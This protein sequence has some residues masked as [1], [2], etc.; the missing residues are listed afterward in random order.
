MPLLLFRSF[1]PWVGVLLNLFQ[2]TLLPE[3]WVHFAYY[4]DW[5]QL[6]RTLDKGLC[7][8]FGYLVTEDASSRRMCSVLHFGLSISWRIGDS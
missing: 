3:T 8:A 5:Q 2:A 1:F 7:D 4:F 6:S